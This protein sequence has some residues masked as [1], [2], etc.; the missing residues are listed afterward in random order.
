MS[1]RASPLDDN[2]VLGE[3]LLRVP[4]QP[5]SLPRGSLVCKRWRRI[6]SDP[7]F[8][9]HFYAGHRKA[10][11]L[12]FFVDRHRDNDFVFNPILEP[13]TASLPNASPWDAP[14]PARAID[15]SCTAAD[16]GVSS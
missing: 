2:V 16:T 9:R 10:P 6:V 4:P 14:S 5:S 11:L 3:I 7:W 13:Q 1:H 15:C 8:L 12:G